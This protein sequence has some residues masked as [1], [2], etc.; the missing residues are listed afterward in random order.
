MKMENKNYKTWK[1]ISKIKSK[2]V[3]IHEQNYLGCVSP[4]SELKMCLFIQMT[5]LMK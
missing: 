4:A 2:I 5:T 3:E 1:Q